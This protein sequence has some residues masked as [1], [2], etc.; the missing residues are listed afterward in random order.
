MY[1]AEQ[2]LYCAVLLQAISDAHGLTPKRFD[3]DEKGRQVDHHAEAKEWFIQAGPDFH[4]ICN[5]AGFDPEFILDIALND[6]P[7]GF[8]KR[9]GSLRAENC[10]RTLPDTI[11]TTKELK[12]LAERCAGPEWNNP[13]YVPGSKFKPK[14]WGRNYKNKV[15]A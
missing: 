15:A 1:N 11:F 9:R 13:D 12:I 4:M 10:G 3:V 5:L 14:P 2:E 7:K 8:K 6:L